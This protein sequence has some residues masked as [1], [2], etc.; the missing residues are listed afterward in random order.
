MN[1]ITLLQLKSSWTTF[2]KNHPK[3]PKFLNALA[4]TDIPADST[5]ELIL[6]TPDDKT[7]SS[8]IKIQ[9]DDI[10]F[11]KSLKNLQ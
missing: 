4:K 11:I 3:F 7:L 2:Q 1:P 6:K 8:K 5:L 9:A 10:E